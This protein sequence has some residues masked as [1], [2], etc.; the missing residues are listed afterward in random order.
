MND[1]ERIG[2]YAI[3]RKLGSGG[4]G[5][6][7]EA[8]DPAG[9]RVAL[10]PLHSG[11]GFA[12][13]VEKEIAA[14]RRVAAFCTARVIAVDL[15]GSRP[16]VVSE[17]VDG[18]SLTQA[19]TDNGPFHADSLRRLAVGVATAMVAIHD[20]GVAHCDLKPRLAPARPSPPGR[21]RGRDGQGILLG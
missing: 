10:K 16:Y 2:D 14:A 12:R 20:A 13:P 21:L 11:S 15:A 18:P 17:F 7:Y 9:E 4:Q 5:V 3:A 19:I 6:V 8:Y 1:F